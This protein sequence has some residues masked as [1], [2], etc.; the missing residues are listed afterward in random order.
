M[1]LLAIVNTSS[2]ILDAASQIQITRTHF[3]L[4]IVQP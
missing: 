4:N 3:V 1:T 2:K